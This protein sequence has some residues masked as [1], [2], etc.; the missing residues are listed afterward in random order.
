MDPSLRKALVIDASVARS[1][2][3]RDHPVSMACREFLQGVL[4]I[5]HSVAMSP[6]LVAEWEKHASLF[7]LR[8]R[9]A[10]QEA[11]KVALE[12]VPADQ[13]LRTSLS[14]IAQDEGHAKAMLKDAHLIEG[15]VKA[16]SA[17]VSLD[18]RARRHF[19]A[20]ARLVPSLRQLVWVNP[21]EPDETALEWLRNG[22]APE[23][24]RCLGFGLP[25]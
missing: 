19:K 5:C 15:A 16:D 23:A 17:V 8:W 4:E 1:A 2:G 18:D 22:A 24:S 20:A 3:T 6:D 25:E 14:A 10:M 12:E 9:R 21:I 13:G 11:A 7:T